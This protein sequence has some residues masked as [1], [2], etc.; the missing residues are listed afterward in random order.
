MA[1]LYIFTIQLQRMSVNLMTNLTTDQLGAT[2]S[3][4]RAIPI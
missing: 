4:F 1:I 3:D 2:E